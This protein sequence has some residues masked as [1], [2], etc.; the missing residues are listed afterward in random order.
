MFSG[1]ST[2][3]DEHYFRHIV[4]IISQKL[5]HL[6]KYYCKGSFLPS[7]SSN[8]VS[9]M[10]M[11]ICGHCV[12]VVQ[13]VP[14]PFRDWFIERVPIPC[15]CCQA[16]SSITESQ[17]SLETQRGR[18]RRAAPQ[19]NLMVAEDKQQQGYLVQIKTTI[20]FIFILIFLRLFLC[21]FL[22]VFFYSYAS[23]NRLVPGG[24]TIWIQ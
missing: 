10:Y 8:C 5:Q 4:L 13:K 17:S 2:D 18:P 3:W 21:N 20:F 16:A 9:L 19:Q 7:L 22:K 14:K 23:S 24:S 11:F 6:S 12:F 15:K 1:K